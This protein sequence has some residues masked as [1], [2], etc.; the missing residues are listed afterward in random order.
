[1]IHDKPNI[2]EPSKSS[3]CTEKSVHAL[4]GYLD[5][6]LSFVQQPEL[7]EHLASCKTCR[8]TMD[9]VLAFRRMSRQEYLALPPAADEVF[10][11]R[12]TRLKQLTDKVD[13]SEDRKPLWN[14]KRSVSLR[15]ALALAGIVFLIGLLVPMPARTEYATALIH[16][17][18]ERVQF[19][20]SDSFL[21]ES[22]IY[23]WVD[24]VTVESA[25]T[26]VELPDQTR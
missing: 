4:H 15:S 11:E 19:E 7:F 22:P 9:S 24:W 25:R 1:M 6:D 16:L 21:I 14:A 8:R 23:N 5:G 10:F 2:S 18:V 12:L 17:E 26:D 3:A 20:P 13:R